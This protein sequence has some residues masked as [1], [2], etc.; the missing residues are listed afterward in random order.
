VG[1]IKTTS[2]EEE[3]VNLDKHIKAFYD[4]KPRGGK[5]IS[6]IADLRRKSIFSFFMK[7]LMLSL[8][9]SLSLPHI[10]INEFIFFSSVF[11]IYVVSE[12]REERRMVE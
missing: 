3:E 1:L 10:N 9:L 5:E 2:E 6:L 4:Y 11:N 8:F 12:W 7:H